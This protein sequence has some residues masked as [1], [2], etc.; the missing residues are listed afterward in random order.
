MREE[1][2]ETL[3]EK[4]KQFANNSFVPFSSVPEGA[5]VLTDDN[6]LIG[7]CAVENADLSCS[8]SAVSVAVL[9]AVSEGHT[10]IKAVIVYSS[11]KKLPYLTGS[12]RQIVHQFG[13]NAEV[14]VANDEKVEK[15]SMFELLPFAFE[16]ED[17]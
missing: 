7:G 9:K 5:C 13:E 11:G 10:K 16:G 3:L 15:Y 14:F 1:E 17:L 2:I 4:A 12:A 6:I 8:A